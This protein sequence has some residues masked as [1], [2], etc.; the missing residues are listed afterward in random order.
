MSKINAIHTARNWLSRDP[1]ILDTE[2]TGLDERAEICDLAIIDST[3]RVLFNQLIKPS[4][5][6]PVQASRIH[7]IDNTMVDFAPTFDR[8]LPELLH[9]LAGRLVLTYN[10]EFDVRM[11]E[12]SARTATGF[13]V[14]LF[15]DGHV[16]KVQPGV[17][18]IQGATVETQARSACI[19][20][21]YAEFAGVPGKY[22]G[23]YKWHKLAEAAAQCGIRPQ[24]AS[25]HRALYDAELARLVLLHM[26]SAKDETL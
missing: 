22:R 5:G 12:Q 8:V 4:Q 3:G 16:V 20:L 26:T 7:G 19:M 1:L 11:F 15:G 9:L 14:P 17:H 23:D 2:T 10:A 13:P 25:L 24:A 21:A 18:V 6:I